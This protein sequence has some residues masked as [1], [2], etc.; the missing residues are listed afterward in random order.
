MIYE[1]ITGHPRS[2]NTSEV[3]SAIQMLEEL[4][5]AYEEHRDK[6]YD[7]DSKTAEAI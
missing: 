6:K 5:R 3:S 4:V 7:N 1:E 2:K